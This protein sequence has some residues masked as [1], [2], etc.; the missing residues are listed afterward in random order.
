MT[1]SNL[2]LARMIYS[3]SCH[4]A[5]AH[6]REPPALKE[7]FH[8]EFYIFWSKLSRKYYHVPSVPFSTLGTHKKRYLKILLKGKQIMIGLALWLF[9]NNTGIQLENVDRIFSIRF[10]P[11]YQRPKSD[12]YSSG[13]VE[14]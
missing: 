13:I 10:H 3:E 14:T 11:S 7:L 8:G 9:F 4:G 5:H 1:S 6:D 2:V 12:I